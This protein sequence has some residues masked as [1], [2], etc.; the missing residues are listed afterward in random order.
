MAVDNSEIRLSRD[1]D[2]QAKTI[3]SSEQQL[4][5]ERDQAL[6]KRSKRAEMV[7]VLQGVITRYDDFFAGISR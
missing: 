2:D 3:L 7:Q 4:A 5:K 6:L 1:I